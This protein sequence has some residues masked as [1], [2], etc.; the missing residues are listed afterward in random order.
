MAM[1]LS[2]SFFNASAKNIKLHFVQ[3][4]KF[5]LSWGYNTEWYTHS[6]VH[7]R[8]NSLGNDYEMLKVK[9]HDHRGWDTGLFNKDL[10]IP[11]YNYR[12]GYFFS[13]NQDWAIELSFDHTKYII[14]DGQSVH[15]KGKLNNKEQDLY[16]PFT[17][18]NGFYYYLN[19][20]A[21]FFLINLVR[22]FSLYRSANKNL[23]VDFLAKAG[24][25]P[26]VPHVENSLF[27]HKNKKHFQFGGWNTGIETALKV[28]IYKY[29][30]L[31]FAQK[32]DYARYSNLRIYEGTARQAF[33]TYELILNLGI[34]FPTGKHNRDFGNGKLKIEN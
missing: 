14:A 12:L 5:Y 9:G 16:I 13:K 23:A 3:N 15:I 19:N 21:N 10:T 7:I 2:F 28:S 6:T 30:Y 17:L 27:G 24:V 22:R 26:V 31:E 8:Q 32:V 33:G 29:A 18:Q 1:L 34:Q 4:G 11:Q 25:G 20:G